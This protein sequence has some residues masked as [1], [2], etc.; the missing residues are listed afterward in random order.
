MPETRDC[1]PECGAVSIQ[2]KSPRYGAQIRENAADYQCDICREHFDEPDEREA[3]HQGPTTGLA[4]R[5]A[6][7]GEHG[8]R[9]D[10]GGA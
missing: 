2:P 4:A 9:G 3:G 10:R 6:A 7:L 5:L 1:C 8:D